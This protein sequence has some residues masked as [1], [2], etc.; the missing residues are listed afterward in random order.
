MA[1]AKKTSGRP[2]SEAQKATEKNLIPN[3]M[4]TPD[5]LRRITT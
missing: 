4:R 1:K 3:D 2:R 5:E